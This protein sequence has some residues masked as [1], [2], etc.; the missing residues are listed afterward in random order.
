MKIKAIQDVAGT[1]NPD[2]FIH[3]NTDADIQEKLRQIH[4][5]H[6]TFTEWKRVEESGKMRWKQVQTKVTKAKF[7][8]M[9]TKDVKEFRAHVDRVKNQ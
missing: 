7:I 6:V 9:F 5:P 3:K 1:K 4:G 8:D 2:N